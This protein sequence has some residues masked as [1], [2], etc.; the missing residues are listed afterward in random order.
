MQ[1][2]RRP[3]LL[4]VALHQVPAIVRLFYFPVSALVRHVSLAFVNVCRLSGGLRRQPR[5]VQR[6]TIPAVRISSIVPLTICHPALQPCCSLTSGESGLSFLSQRIFWLE[7]VNPLGAGDCGKVQVW[8]ELGHTNWGA[9]VNLLPSWINIRW[10]GVRFVGLLVR[11][12]G[13]SLLVNR[14]AVTHSG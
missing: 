14:I 12:T 4:F 11:W 5:C 2:H 10:W 3:L 9:D 8:P 13:I 6:P 1:L 7:Q